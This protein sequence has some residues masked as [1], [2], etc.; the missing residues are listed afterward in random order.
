MKKGKTQ[1]KTKV[2]PAKNANCGIGTRATVKEKLLKK[3]GYTPK[4][5]IAV[6]VQGKSGFCTST[7]TI[8][9]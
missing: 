6:K 9:A 5:L 1:K 3:L 2:V 4:K 8:P 7:R